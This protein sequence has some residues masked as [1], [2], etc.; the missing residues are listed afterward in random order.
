MGGSLQRRAQ[1]EA[2]RNLLSP[3]IPPPFQ[4]DAYSHPSPFLIIRT[5]VSISRDLLA[6]R[7]CLKS[8]TPV[9]TLAIQN[10]NFSSNRSQDTRCDTRHKTELGA[11]GYSHEVSL[12][13][14][15]I[16]RRGRLGSHCSYDR[17]LRVLKRALWS[18]GMRN[19]F[20][21][22]VMPRRKSWW[23]Q[24]TRRGQFFTLFSLQLSTPAAN[25]VSSFF[26]SQSA[27]A[28]TTVLPGQRCHPVQQAE[29][30]RVRPLLP[31]GAGGRH[32]SRQ[33]SSLLSSTRY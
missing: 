9:T 5:P 17:Y 27:A 24:L 33:V 22:Y 3:H 14:S 7:A 11:H 19:Y 10:L 13:G 18:W 32:A 4:L 15:F 8:N 2:R 30:P 1:R 28:V 20:F 16:R 6:Y 29:K 21:R 31:D 26:H 23:V 25:P 12:T